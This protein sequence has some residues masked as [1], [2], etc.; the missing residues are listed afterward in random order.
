MNSRRPVLLLLIF[1]ALM[2]AIGVAMSELTGHDEPR[3]A[4]IARAMALTGDYAAP[5]LNGVLFNEYPPL[6]YIPTAWLI[7][8]FG[9]NETAA[10]AADIIYFVGTVFLTYRIGRRLY[11]ER[12]GIAAAWMLATMA[13][14]VGIF[15]VCLVDPALVFYI[16]FSIFGYAEASRAETPA[17]A[18][19]AAFFAGMAFA[20]LTKGIIGFAFPAAACAADLLWTRRWKLL[21]LQYL[22]EGA[23]CFAAPIAVWMAALEWSGDGAVWREVIRQSV[24]RFSSSSADH[25]N[26]IYYYFGPVDYLT[27]PANLLVCGACIYDTLRRFRPMGRAVFDQRASLPAIAFIVM[28]GALL[29]ASAKRNIYLAPLYP[30][31]AILAGAVWMQMIERGVR[32]PSGKTLAIAIVLYGIALGAGDRLRTRDKDREDTYAPIFDILKQAGGNAINTFLYHPTEGLDGAAVFYLGAATAR[33]GREKASEDPSMFDS[34]NKFVVAEMMPKDLD[35]TEILR[36]FGKELKE[37]RRTSYR[38]Q[39]VVVG[40]IQ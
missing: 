27:L 4:G 3:V 19:G 6:G 35:I 21:K 36:K 26:P 7:K 29:A 34:H 20:F 1:T 28:F 39:I 2:G 37:L 5:R 16:T 14:A 18:H 33:A 30:Q 15:K 38:Q 17:R 40:I 24:F 31:V 10:H 8:L 23:L 22:A 13:G 12:G 25:N 9:A 11:G 32:L